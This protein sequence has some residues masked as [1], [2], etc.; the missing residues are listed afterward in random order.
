VRLF[1]VPTG[2]PRAVLPGLAGTARTVAFAPDGKRLA[3][4]GEAVKV[5]V[6]DL[7]TDPPK[8]HAELSDH[9]PPATVA[10]APDGKTIVTGDGAPIP[11]PEEIQTPVE[12]LAFSPDGKTLSA[13]G[14]W[15]RAIS[16]W[17]VS[18]PVPKKRLLADGP[19]RRVRALAWSQDGRQLVAGSDADNLAH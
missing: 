18:Q 10:F 6:W 4:A 8:L 19:I 9:A 15:N 7:T 3:A 16:Q 14:W 2:K 17:D 12:G 1:D 5:R 13:V 11:Y